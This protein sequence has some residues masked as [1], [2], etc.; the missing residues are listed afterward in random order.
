M[1]K[2]KLM[3]LVN[4]LMG[5]VTFSNDASKHGE[6]NIN[7][8]DDSK[9]TIETPVLILIPAGLMGWV[10]ATH[11]T[12]WEIHGNKHISPGRDCRQC[13]TPSPQD[14]TLLVPMR[15]TAKMV[16]LQTQCIILNQIWCC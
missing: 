2:W 15:S 12:P 11:H 8:S 7:K 1:W 14:I 6:K 3:E 10:A 9:S 16:G 5:F 4:N 13:P